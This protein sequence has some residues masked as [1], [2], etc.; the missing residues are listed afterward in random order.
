L[1]IYFSRYVE[2]GDQIAL[3]YGGSEAHKKV[4]STGATSNIQGPMG[5][6]RFHVKFHP[7]IIFGRASFHI[8]SQHKEL[9]TSIRRYYSNAFTDRLKQDA[10]NLFLG[11]YAPSRNTL[12]LWE[13][14]NDSYLHNFHVNAGRG[15][16]QSMKTYQE[17][18]G[19]DWDDIEEIDQD[20]KTQLQHK[21]NESARSLS[22]TDNSW[23][24]ERV[25]ERCKSQNDALSLW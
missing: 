23:R 17:M 22:I 13:L 16:L 6:V 4:A 14:D 24:I 2:I 10:M 20:R 21:R 5:K 8:C 15:S 25:K 3:Q 18:F 7:M 9:L 11:Y 1:Y 12:P 19:I